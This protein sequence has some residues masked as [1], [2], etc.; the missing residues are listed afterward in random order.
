VLIEV[1]KAGFVNKGAQLMLLAIQQQV[2]QRYPEAHLA[3]APS[4]NSGSQPLHRLREHGMF[5][6]SA[7][8]RGGIQWGDLAACL[9][10]SI[11][12][13][14]GLVLDREIDG[15]FDAAGF[16]YG[17]PWPDRNLAELANAARRWRRRDTALVL[18]PQAFGR[19]NSHSAQDDIRVVVDAAALIYA[20]DDQSLNNLRE[21]VGDHASL[22]LAPDFT[23]LLEGCL[24]EP[25]LAS[26]LRTS[27]AIVPNARML[28]K[29]SPVVRDQYLPFLQ[30]CITNLHARGLG[31]ALIVHGGSE[32]QALAE[33]LHH[34]HPDCLLIT[35][36]DPVRL[37]GLLGVCRGSIGSRYHGLVSC[38]GQG[39]PAF[40]TSWSH[41]YQAL[42][43]DYNFKAGLI[44]SLSMDVA[45]EL[46]QHLAD[47]HWMK[48]TQES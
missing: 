13:S 11:R 48:A 34:S 3:M 46:S 21:A 9:P 37:K 23:S 19:F 26:Q 8:W 44:H 28:D 7:F 16:A 27:I 1:R 18:L 38:L 12:Q 31:I 35:E 2:L 43:A 40:G 24:P 14:L 47:D 42:F 32:D 45:D 39:V 33:Q 29:T 30:H 25:Q 15:V 4:R 6:K 36:P 22:R 17:S 5:A 20:R 10:H 41:K